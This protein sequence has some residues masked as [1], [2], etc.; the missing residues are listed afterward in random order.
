MGAVWTHER[1]PCRCPKAGAQIGHHQA[2][3]GPFRY[4]SSSKR[5]H[6]SGCTFYA[7]AGCEDTRSLALPILPFLGGTL[8]LFSIVYTRQR[9]T[10]F[11]SIK[12]W[13]TTA[14]ASSPAFSLFSQLFE[15][16]FHLNCVST[17]GKY[18]Q[19]TSDCVVSANLA[20]LRQLLAKLES[21]VVAGHAF[22]SEKDEFGNTLLFVSGTIGQN[23]LFSDF[24]FFPS[25]TYQLE[26]RTSCWCAN[27]Y[28]E[29]R[30]APTPSSNSSSESLS[31]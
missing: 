21:L 6:L 8:E 12:Y 22:P 19:V 14:R 26:F 4:Q 10:S 13:R 2:R 28:L 15:W 5:R 16:D 25:Q 7:E 3:L 24:F 31:A 17:I 1:A 9:L 11:S 23:L 30:S 27:S 29:P 20:S 18:Q